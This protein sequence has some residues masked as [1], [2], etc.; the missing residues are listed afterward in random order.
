MQEGVDDHR[1]IDAQGRS[2]RIA[3]QWWQSYNASSPTRAT[4]CCVLLLLHRSARAVRSKE[5]SPELVRLVVKDINNVGHTRI[6]V[7]SDDEPAI[8]ALAG[9][10]SEQRAHLTVVEESLGWE[11]QANRLAEWNGVCKAPRGYSE[12]LGLIWKGAS[13]RLRPI[14]TQS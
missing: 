4:Q 9:S 11:P 6:V 7:K 12:P 1:N 5:T 3:H 14:I 2:A 10:V 13:G 8:K